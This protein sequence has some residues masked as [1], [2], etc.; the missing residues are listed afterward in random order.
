MVKRKLRQILLAGLTAALPVFANAAPAACGTVI[1]P[2]GIGTGAP[3]A[4]VNSLN[5]FLINSLYDGEAASLLYKGLIW[6]NR[7][8]KIDWSRSLA[9][10]IDV[11]KHNTVFTVTMR[12]WNWSDGKPVTSKDVKYTYELIK[13]LGPTY[14]SYGTGGMPTAVKRFKILGPERFQITTKHPV[15]PEW[16]EFL[17][18]G[19][20]EPYPSHVWSKYSINQMW[21]RQSSAGF[22]KVVDGP[23]RIISFKMGRHIIFGLN[24]S[25]QGHKPQ[26]RRFIMK[27]LHSAGSEIEGMRSGT[28]DMSNLP[29]SL[30]SAAHRVK[31]V[32]IMQM[33]PN[34]GFDYIQ[35]NFKNPK[36][37]FFRD[38]DVRQAIADAINQKAAIALLFHNT[39]HEQ[40]GPVPVD[41]PTFLSPSAKAGKY[42][43]GYDPAKARKLLEKA[44]W[45]MGPGGVRMKDGKR[46]EFTYL[47][48][49]GGATAELDNE[50]MQQ[51]LQA[52]GIDMRIRQVTFNQLLALS[53]KPLAWEAMAFGWTLPAYPSN[54]AQFRTGAPYN[55]EGYSDKKMDQL[56]DAV[57]T[58]PGNQAL[59][60]YQ[61]YTSA[62]QPEI[63]IPEPGSVVLIRKGLRGVNKAFPPN[64][65]WSPQYLHFTTPPCGHA[66][67]AENTPP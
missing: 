23:F 47:Q 30:W 57:T 15:N 51:N 67:V 12:P 27:F 44:G 38:L 5:P 41:P 35:I 21:R 3:P 61:D 31:N 2:P 26:I 64:G 52:V 10:K 50:M 36:V 18:I 45:K 66:T 13:K 49:S 9:T 1:V 56:L 43:V 48:S 63:F 28:L 46:L 16:F 8:H 32:R 59:Y 60:E 34:F 58:Q 33:K 55:Q 53:Q 24:P 40:Y 20:L 62:Q 42:P 17:G 39:S 4:S 54:G 11:S 29:F 19:Q 37:S 6:V 25:Y 14:L 65:N 7:D 22:F